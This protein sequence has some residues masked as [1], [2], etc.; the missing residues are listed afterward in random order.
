M[1]RP[2]AITQLPTGLP[3]VAN[4]AGDNPVRRRRRKKD[5][6]PG[7]KRNRKVSAGNQNNEDGKKTI[8]I[9]F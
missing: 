5:K 6:K 9:S 8:N 7:S 4:V 2:V 3:V 1:A